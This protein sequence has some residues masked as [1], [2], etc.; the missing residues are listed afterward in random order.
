MRVLVVHNFY[1]NPGGED[2]V[3][4]EELSL[5][6]RSGVDVDLYSVTNDD[7]T[8]RVHTLATALQVVY[9]P[10][11]KRALGKK[12]AEFKPDVVHIHN[13]FPRLS[14][15][16]L[17]ACRGAGAPSVLT[18]HNYRIMCPSMLLYP[19]EKMRERSLQHP[20]WW[21]VPRRVYRNS[22]GGTL[23]LSVMVEFHKRALT[24]SRKVDRFIALT[25]RAKQKFVLGGLPAEKIVVKPNCAA[26]PPSFAGLQRHGALFVGRLDQQKGVPTLL[27]AWKS[28]DYPLKI[29]GDG[30]LTPL[31]EQSVNNRIIYLGRQP[32]EV[33]QKE[34]QSAKFLVLP[35]FGYEMFPITLLEAFS[36]GLPVIGSA[37]PAL[38]ELVE[39]GVTGLIFPSGNSAAL[40]EHVRWAVA[41][42]A[43]LDEIGS[44]ARAAYE[45]RYTPE[46]NFRRLMEIYSS[47][48]LD[49]R[50]DSP[51]AADS[52]DASPAD[53]I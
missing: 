46:I 37:I 44:R 39:P 15:S 14:P 13:F 9:N 21:T 49:R 26:R 16:I 25:N 50:R 36:N 6:Q 8:G 2:S 29:V 19:E 30:P 47:L 11:A 27:E 12:L 20:C 17:D 42:P 34:M 38:E 18:L 43:A 35:S 22:L 51:R 3:V 7:I 48:R 1:Q 28:L 53:A 33:V 40:A 45:E 32:R 31:V 52:D 24:W 10:W 5:L 23:A 4:R 41:N